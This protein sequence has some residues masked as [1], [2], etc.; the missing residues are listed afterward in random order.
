VNRPTSG[1]EEVQLAALRHQVILKSLQARGQVSANGLAE[2]LGV[3]HET[4]RKDLLFLQERGLLPV[5]EFVS[6]CPVAARVG[7]CFRGEGFLA[8]SRRRHSLMALTS[9]Y[10]CQAA[11]AIAVFRRFGRRPAAA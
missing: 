2:H 9:S 4:V 3:T 8:A 7:S 6:S 11:K 10:V 5:K 1:S